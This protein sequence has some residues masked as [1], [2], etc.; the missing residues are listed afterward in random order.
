L[1][2][3]EGDD[4]AIVVKFTTTGYKYPVAI[5]NRYA[6]YA[7]SATA[8]PGESYISSGGTTFT[9]IT[10]YSGFENANVCIRG[11]T[12][13]LAATP[14]VIT[15]APVT[16][17]TVGKLYSYDVDASGYPPPAYALT[18]YPDGMTIDP[19]T[20]LIQWT[21][22]TTGGFDVEVMASNGLSPDAYQGFTINV[23]QPPPYVDDVA[24]ADIAVQGSVAGVYADTHFANNVYQAVTEVREGNPARGYSSLEHKVDDK[25]HRRRYRDLLRRGLPD[26]QRR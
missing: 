6:G 13:P 17:G 8:N 4:F 14:P 25:C 22:V 7:S 3:R 18:I 12:V 26:C 21:P 10:T 23:S 15:S 11:L 24:Y 20:G 2:L 1:S 16:V 5:E 9:D 19:A